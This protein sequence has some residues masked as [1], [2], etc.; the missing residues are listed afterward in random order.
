MNRHTGVI[1][2]Q[3]IYRVADQSLTVSFSNGSVLSPLDD[4]PVSVSFP[5]DGFR[6]HTHDEFQALC[7]LR[8]DLYDVV[9][10]LRLVNGQFLTDRP[11]L[12]ESEI[13]SMRHILVHL[14]K[15]NS[16]C[17]LTLSY[18]AVQTMGSSSL[19]EVSAIH[20]QCP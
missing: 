18:I 12:D 9:G 14:Q 6:F 1:S 3:E 7:G 2:K 17:C 10:H 8:G 20:E 5:P 15:K 16:G 4:I 13:I 19:F 11:V